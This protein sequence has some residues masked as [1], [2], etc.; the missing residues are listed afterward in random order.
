ML[1]DARFRK[2]DEGETTD[3]FYELLIQ[4]TRRF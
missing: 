4:D 1:L 2:H 3:L